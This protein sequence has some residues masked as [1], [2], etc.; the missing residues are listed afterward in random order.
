MQYEARVL[1]FTKVS[2]EADYEKTDLNE[3]DK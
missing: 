1:L 2:T 3:L